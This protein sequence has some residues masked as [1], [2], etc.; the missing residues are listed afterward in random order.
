MDALFGA[1]YYDPKVVTWLSTD[2]ALEH[3]IP[4]ASQLFF[5]IEPLLPE[6]NLAGLGGIYNSK[7]MNVYQ[8]TLCNP[9]KFIDKD[10]NAAWI[11]VPV[12]IYFLTKGTRSIGEGGETDAEY[13]SR[14]ADELSTFIPGKR[15]TSV[16][17]YLGIQFGKTVTKKQLTKV[18]SKMG[19]RALKK[20]NVRDKG[21]KKIVDQLFR[22][23]DKFKG[24]TAGKLVHEIL[25]KKP[26]KH[27][28]KAKDRVTE[29]KNY[30]KGNAKKLS[31]AD[32]QALGDVIMDL[33]KAIKLSESAK[34][35]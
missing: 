28:Q 23:K 27:L 15:A 29:L 34:G 26:L 32:R 18:L 33:N 35:E 24:G 31:R 5:P 22:S 12:A 16:A 20:P 25:E 14:V 30:L 2:P 7:N 6:M 8:Y 9:V 21:A 3:Y 19:F 4:R 13:Y 10:G 17:K 1:R 11:I